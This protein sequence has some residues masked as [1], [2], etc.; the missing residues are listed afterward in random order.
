MKSHDLIL[1][2]TL[3]TDVTGIEMNRSPPFIHLLTND[4]PYLF[5]NTKRTYSLFLLLL[6][7]LSGHILQQ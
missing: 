3:P 5:K 4:I 1:Q 7:F 2:D 6:I